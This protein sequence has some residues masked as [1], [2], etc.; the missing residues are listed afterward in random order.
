M[1][2]EI[3]LLLAEFCKL[4]ADDKEVAHRFFDQAFA[5]VLLVFID[6]HGAFLEFLAG[7][8]ENGLAAFELGFDGGDGAEDFRFIKV[9]D[10]AGEVGEFDA[11]FGVFETFGETSAFVVDEDELDFVRTKIDGKG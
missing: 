10:G 2:H 8:V 5:I 6:I 11:E 3:G 7:G 9:G 1:I 4:V